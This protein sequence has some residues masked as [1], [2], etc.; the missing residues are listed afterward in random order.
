MTNFL[1]TILKVE[2]CE[3]QE[4][5]PDEIWRAEDEWDRAEEIRKV[6][7]NKK[8]M[9]PPKAISNCGRIKTKQG[10]VRYGCYRNGEHKYNGALVHRLVG[11]AFND[12]IKDDPNRQGYTPE[13]TV[14]RH[15]NKHELKKR[16]IDVKKKYR[17]DKEGR[18]VLSNHIDTLEFG[19]HTDNMQDLSNHKIHTDKQDPK[20]AFRVTPLRTNLPEIPGTFHSVLEFLKFV[21]EQNIEVTFHGGSVLLALKGKFKQT[22]GYKFSYV[23]TQ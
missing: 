17:T 7:E 3:D 4:D 14:V 22:S 23:K 16:G 9:V 2:F 8:D 5:L 10:K 13:H 11:L 15:I 12:Y 18:K 21:E 19:S 1:Q 20:N 6:F